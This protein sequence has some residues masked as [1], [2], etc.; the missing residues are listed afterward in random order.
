[1]PEGDLEGGYEYGSASM[2]LVSRNKK[3]RGKDHGADV[4][5]DG[6]EE[7]ERLNAH[8]APDAGPSPSRYKDRAGSV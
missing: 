2:P 6:D 4:L 8:A 3:R 7:L 1:M 5:F